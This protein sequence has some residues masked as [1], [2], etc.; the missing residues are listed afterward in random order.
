[1]R[2]ESGGGMVHGYGLAASQLDRIKSKGLPLTICVDKVAA[3]G[4]YMMAC[5]ADRIVA[6]P[7]A[8]I[9][10]I[11]VVAQIP[12][13]HRLLQKHAIDVELMTAGKHKRTLTVLGE[14]TDQGREKFREELDDTHRL[15]KNFVVD[16]RPGVDIDG[17]ATG[18]VWFGTRAQELGLVDS[19]QTSDDYLVSQLDTADIY[20]IAYVHKRSLSQRI[21]IA[22]A[23]GSDYLLMR[24]LRYLT[25][26]KH[27]G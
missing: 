8:V 12:N 13:I 20:E 21:G 7:F 14:N 10:S 2:L 15:F 18:E 5:V 27:I 9:G 16:H 24:W 4:G 1:M 25:G 3:S 19:L 22:A 11:G 6:A 23:E 17:V 26:L